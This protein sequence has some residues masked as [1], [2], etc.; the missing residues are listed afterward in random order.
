[1]ATKLYG[2]FGLSNFLIN[3]LAILTHLDKQGPKSSGHSHIFEFLYALLEPAE[4][5]F[6]S[7]NLLG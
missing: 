2:K 7:V 4:K 5:D 1:M 3:S 6:P